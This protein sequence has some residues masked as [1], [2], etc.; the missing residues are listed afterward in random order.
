[1]SM[2]AHK[3]IRLFYD[4]L[5]LMNLRQPVSVFFS[6]T[7]F[8]VCALVRVTMSPFPNALWILLYI[9]RKFHQFSTL[10]LHRTKMTNVRARRQ[11]TALASCG[12]KR[13]R[14]IF[15]RWRAAF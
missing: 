13:G 11:R 10:A 8:D 4:A 1:M 12:E 15:T 9:F 7:Y 14:A 2:S 3:N 5:I 6:A